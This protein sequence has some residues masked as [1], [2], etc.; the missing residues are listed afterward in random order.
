MP[1][2]DVIRR[3]G[4]SEPYPDAVAVKK[5]VQALEKQCLP[6]NI[7]ETD[8]LAGTSQEIIAPHDGKLSSLFVTVSKTVTTGGVVSVNVNGIPVA[9]LNVTVADGAV[10]GT[11]VS[12]EVVTG[13]GTEKVRRGDRIEI[14]PAAA[15]ATAGAINGFVELT[16]DA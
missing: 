3:S 6:F 9:G 8:T 10:K 12:D 14:V 2:S 5:A 11:R 7:N 4:A 16:M 1:I 13:D 15:F